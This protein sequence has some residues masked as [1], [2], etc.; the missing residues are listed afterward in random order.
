MAYLVSDAAAGSTAAR[1]LQQ[2]VFGAQYD[3][4]NAAAAAQEVQVKLQ[5]DQANL[6]KTK[7]S[8]LVAE[9]GFKAS[10]DSKVV[11]QKIIQSPEGQAAL[12]DNPPEFVK[13]VGIAQMGA[14]DVENGVNTLKAGADLETKQVTAQL[15][16][17]ELER[18]GYG[19]ALAAINKASEEQ[20]PE[21]LNKM[22]ETMKASI[23]KSIPNFFEQTDRK[24]QKAQL[25]ALVANG[26]GK[27][28]MATVEARLKLYDTQLK[29]KEEMLKIQEQ[30]L[31]NKRA[32]GG[33]N[34]KREDHQFAQARRD[35]ARIDTEF[36]KPLQEASDAFKKAAEED[37]KKGLYGYMSSEIESA[38]DSTEKKESLKSTKAWRNLQ[39]IQKEVLEKKLDALEGMPEGKEK[40]RLF[41]VYNKQL[42][43]LDTAPSPA[44]K[45]SKPEP[46]TNE[47]KQAPTIE[48]ALKSQG[49]AYE[50][51]KFDYKLMP[52]GSVASRPKQVATKSESTSGLLDKGNID[53]TKRPV[54]KNKDG[55]IST[56]RSMSF[57][58]DGKEVLIP[59]VVGDKVVSDKEA[60]EHYRKTGEHLGKFDT[61]K[62]A[63][64]YAKKLHEDQDK[65][66]SKKDSSS[67]RSYSTY[68]KAKS[69]L[70]R[71][72]K[73]APSKTKTVS[74]GVGAS[75][76]EIPN[77]EYEAWYK[78]NQ[79]KVDELTAKIEAN[80]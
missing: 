44:L 13:L 1:T 30:T 40:E 45:E 60:I 55:S 59:T 17:H 56:V 74:A 79:S 22:P 50:P 6:Q 25:E 47:S 73:E 49:V 3:Q 78:K 62:A 70:D 7:L 9:T 26:S 20:I 65:M 39:S 8:N 42:T 15:K 4:A 64:A 52:D 72:Q 37:K 28:D 2:N 14:N 61:P 71:M 19:T 43:S 67:E 29:I 68:L 23:K 80:K 63:N 36:K 41:D 35:A 16:K 51:N 54:V 12:K 46:K 5:Q 38:R 34:T 77:P 27:N 75:T 21:L 32:N 10:E 69:E 76:K 58:E 48:S 66:Y 33:D 57:N 18:E 24:L 11:L 31:E 53:L